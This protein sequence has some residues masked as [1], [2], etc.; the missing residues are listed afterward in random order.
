[1]SDLFCEVPE[2]LDAI[3]QCKE[4]I[5]RIKSQRKLDGSRHSRTLLSA[6]NNLAVCNIKNRNADEAARLFLEALALV[7]RTPPV[8]LHNMRFLSELSSVRGTLKLDDKYRSKLTIAIASHN[9]EDPK[10]KLQL[11]WYYSLD[12]DVPSA[13]ENELSVSGVHPPDASLELIASGTGVVCAPGY[14]VTVN[15]AVIHPY[16][17]ASLATIALTNGASSWILKP[18]QR[19]FATQPRKRV[20]SGSNTV[21][22]S[23]SDWKEKTNYDLNQ[24][25]SDSNQSFGIGSPVGGTGTTTTNANFNFG[26]SETNTRMTGNRT[27][28]GISSTRT[29]SATTNYTLTN[30]TDG[31]AEAELA[32]L[33]IDGLRIEPCLFADELPT[34]NSKVEILGYQRGPSMLKDGQQKISGNVLNVLKANQFSLDAPILGGNRGSLCFDL[35]YRVIGITWKTGQKPVGGYCYTTSA[36]KNW[37]GSTAQT[38]DLRFADG[39]DN[40][41]NEKRLRDATVPVLVWGR[42]SD[43]DMSNPIYNQ[44]YN[45]DN[46]IDLFVVRDDW[47]FACGGDGKAPC[48]TCF[49]QAKIKSGMRTDFL[50]NDPVTGTP[51]TRT[52]ANM[53]TCPTCNGKN[54]IICTQCQ[55]GRLPGNAKLNLGQ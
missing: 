41:L 2:L 43:V 15:P 1:M 21:A 9:L 16:R 35:S 47:C 17:T 10:K 49:G 48:P 28:Q 7:D 40:R 53:V 22:D 45:D 32:I 50:G 12:F 6:Y 36:I 13:L 18:A 51:I 31:T 54:Q 33:Q 42:R 23:V 25:T 24:R 20:T 39:T 11:G 4:A 27:A 38:A 37:F 55:R 52:A 14:V 34:P 19:V 26:N 3:K 29:V 46:L 30:P 8:L 44:F 5:N